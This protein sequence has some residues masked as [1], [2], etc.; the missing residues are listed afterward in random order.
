MIEVTR[1]PENTSLSVDATEPRQT[2]LPPGRR[3]AEAIANGVNALVRGAGEVAAELP[4]GEIVAAATREAGGSSA[5]AGAGAGERP[6][7]PG[8]AGD[9]GGSGGGE[10]IDEYWKLQQ[11]SQDFNLQFLQ[12]QE[13]LSQENRR[14]SALSNVLKARHDTA[15]TVIQNIR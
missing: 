6:E 15:K 5:G 7:G 12:L 4:G 14:F 13:S 10:A 11:Q 9:A 8:G 3:F 2:P 1:M